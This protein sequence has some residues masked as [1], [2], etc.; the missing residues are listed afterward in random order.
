MDSTESEDLVYVV[1]RQIENGFVSTPHH[2]AVAVAAQR[3]S[4]MLNIECAQN[5][6]WQ[7]LFWCAA[8][9]GRRPEVAFIGVRPFREYVSTQ[10]ADPQE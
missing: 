3:A 8:R 1:S 2:E 9:S 6:V 4:L 10:E 5:I 7:R